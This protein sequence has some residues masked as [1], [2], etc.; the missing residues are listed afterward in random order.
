MLT[1]LMSK[2]RKPKTVSVT[3]VTNTTATPKA[4]TIP[5][6]VTIPGQVP[7]VLRATNLTEVKAQVRE[8]HGLKR[9]PAGTTV[10]RLA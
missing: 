6:S 9:L 8:A 7:V 3:N 10:E 5:Y 4:K 1:R 2:L